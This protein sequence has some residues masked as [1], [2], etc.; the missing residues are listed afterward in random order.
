MRSLVSVSASV[1]LLAGCASKQDSPYTYQRTVLPAD[2]SNLYAKQ[3]VASTGFSQSRVEPAPTTISWPRVIMTGSTTNTVHQPQVDSWDG[4]TLTVR[5][6][7]GVQGP[8]QPQVM[9]GVITVQ[10]TTSV[11]KT[12]RVVQLKDAKIIHADFPS[13]PNRAQEIANALQQQWPKQVQV[14]SL[15]RLE[16]SL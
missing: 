3:D 8:G 2:A 6:A 13:A 4:R 9:Y 5:H 1:L 15:D 14:E 10:S 16:A 7:V 11:D 12:E